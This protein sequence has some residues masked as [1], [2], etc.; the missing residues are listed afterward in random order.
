RQRPCGRASAAR[1]WNDLGQGRRR[2]L[3]GALAQRQLKQPDSIFTP[4]FEAVSFADFGLVEP[5]GAFV[6]ALKWPINRE[7][8]A[9]HAHHGHGIDQRGRVKV[10]RRGEMK[11]LAK[12][13]RDAVL[14]WIFVLRLHPAVAI[15]NTPKIDG[16]A[17]ADVA[18]H[19]LQFRALIEDSATNQAQ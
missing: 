18:E 8:H 6:D 1:Q 12:V 15:V 3:S 13:M 17:F 11:L 9:V 14:R 16:N 7:H 5:L 2:A 4:N 10:T 19:Y